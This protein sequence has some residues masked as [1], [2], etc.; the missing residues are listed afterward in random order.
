VAAERRLQLKGDSGKSD[1]EGP[2]PKHANKVVKLLDRSAATLTAAL[3]KP[4]NKEALGT[5]V[6]TACKSAN[7]AIVL[8]SAD[9]LLGQDKGVRAALNTLTTA[10]KAA[11]THLGGVDP[12]ALA[13]FVRVS[14][15][16][17]ADIAKAEADKDRKTASAATRGSLGAARAMLAGAKAADTS[18]SGEKVEDRLTSALYSLSGFRSTRGKALADGEQEVADAWGELITARLEAAAKILRGP[19]NRAAISNDYLRGLKDDLANVRPPPG[20]DDAKHHHS[21]IRFG[22]NLIDK[23]R[24]G[25]GS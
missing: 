21:A 9:P 23:E 1:Q 7:R 18:D 14:E 15:W 19:R 16:L 20:L 12:K 3:A 11:Q 4:D 13:D 17:N 10:C 2:R 24:S 25:S 5:S 8:I 22:V 6:Q